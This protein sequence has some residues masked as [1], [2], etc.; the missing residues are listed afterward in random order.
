MEHEAYNS[1][2]RAIEQILMK[3]RYIMD[4]YLRRSTENNDPATRQIYLDIVQLRQK[5]YLEM[6]QHLAQVKSQVQIMD[7]INNIFW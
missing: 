4:D 1:V 2:I 6:E 5:Q 3:E 7:E